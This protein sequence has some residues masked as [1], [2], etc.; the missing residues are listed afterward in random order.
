[1]KLKCEDFGK[2]FDEADAICIS[3]TVDFWGGSCSL[4]SFPVCPFC[5]SENIGEDEEEETHD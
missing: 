4:P 2:T 5:G 3:D 1:M